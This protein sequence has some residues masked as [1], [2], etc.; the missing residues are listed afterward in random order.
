MGKQIK[1]YKN[2]STSFNFKNKND[3]Q[4][5]EKVKQIKNQIKGKRRI[6]KEDTQI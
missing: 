3:E 6:K 5:K 4:Y 2:K 1:E